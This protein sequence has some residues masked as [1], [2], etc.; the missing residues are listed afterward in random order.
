MILKSW[1]IPEKSKLYKDLK[2]QDLFTPEGMAKVNAIIEAAST[3]RHGDKILA[4]FDHAV[5]AQHAEKINASIPKAKAAE[6]VVTPKAKAAEEVVTPKAKAA[7]EVVTPKAKAAEEVVTP[8]AEEVVTPKAEEVVI[9][10][11][12]E[13][14]E[15]VIPEA[16]EAAE[17][18]IPEA[19]AAE[20]VVTPEAEAAEEVVTP[21]TKRVPKVKPVA[22]VKPVAPEEVAIVKPVVQAKPK[23]RGEQVTALK[24]SVFEPSDENMSVLKSH[25]KNKNALALAATGTATVGEV[26]GLLK[27]K[28]SI[29]FMG[30]LADRQ[31]KTPIAAGLKVEPITRASKENP[32]SNRA[33]LKEYQDQARAG[34]FNLKDPKIQELDRKLKATDLGMHTM[35]HNIHD[36]AKKE[37]A[38]RAEAEET[39]QLKERVAKQVAEKNKQKPSNV[40]VADGYSVYE[41]N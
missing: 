20:E 11:A 19:E 23:S 1:G 25:T 18:V 28:E 9:P 40:V 12:E 3:S 32:I 41:R 5:Y 24:E 38:L 26:H 10:E 34:T 7:A 39:K 30:D 15:V 37:N 33:V 14:A 35:L 29:N 6:E 4:G 2:S 27:G 13:A 31:V 8:K 36:R 21:P 17:V 22:A 16:E